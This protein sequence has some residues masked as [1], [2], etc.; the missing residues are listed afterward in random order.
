[1]SRRDIQAAPNFNFLFD[2]CRHSKVSVALTGTYVACMSAAALVV[3]PN[4][5]QVVH[6][7]S[8]NVVVVTLIITHAF[9]HQTS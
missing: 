2:I 6:V 9:D 3:L 4:L 1:M 7:L 5:L 8:M